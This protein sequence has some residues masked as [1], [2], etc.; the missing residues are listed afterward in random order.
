MADPLHLVKV[1]I[2]ASQL[3]RVARRKHVALRELDEGYLCH[4]VMRDLWQGAAPGPFVLRGRGAV[5]EA[6]GYSRWA[7]DS[8]VERARASVD[9]SALAAI[10][11]LGAVASKPV[12]ELPA[13]KRVGFLLR[14]CPVVRLATAA[15]GHRAGA[16]VDAF[17]ARC[18]REGRD[19]VVSREET[20]RQ[21]LS[22]RL[23]REENGVTTVTVQVDSLSRERL[24]RRTLGEERRARGIERSDVRFSGTLT[25]VD[26]QLF[27]GVLARG[28]GRH[29]AFGFGALILVPPGTSWGRATG[30]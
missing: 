20:Y 3:A 11:D 15:C 24:V 18:F 2:L 26:P 7:A 28:L 21:W 6:W 17:L 12:P 16:E 13:G 23:A 8:L 29:R 1:P 14:G 25:V 27:R 5:L 10:A 19:A 30:A 22:D 4:C 9:R